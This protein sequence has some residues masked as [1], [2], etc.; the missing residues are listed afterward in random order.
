MIDVPPYAVSFKPVGFSGGLTCN[1][2]Y[3]CKGRTLTSAPVSNL[4]FRPPPF[5]D[6]LA[7]QAEA[8]LIPSKLTGSIVRL[9][10]SSTDEFELVLFGSTS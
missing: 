6:K 1:S 4:T 3:T 5:V 9:G 7:N 2:L 10:E 8:L